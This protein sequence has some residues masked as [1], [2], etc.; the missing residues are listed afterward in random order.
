MNPSIR[1]LEAFSLVYK[2]GSVSKAADRM[3]ISQSAVSVLLRQLETTLETRLFDRTTRSLQPTAAA[4]EAIVSANR[5]LQEVGRLAHAMKSLA[6]KSLGRVTFAVTAALAAS[7]FPAILK[8]FM[9]RYPQVEIVIQDVPH[10]Q[11]GRI[12]LDDEVEFSI[13]GPP[14]SKNPELRYEALAN[15]LV[16][17]IDLN[18]GQAAGSTIKWSEVL[19]KPTI[20]IHR[21]VGIRDLIDRILLEHS[22]EFTPT[23]EV[24]FLSTALAMT[25]QG[26]GISILPGYLCPADLYPTLR[27]RHLVAPQILR[28]L[29]IVTRPDRSLSAAAEAFIAI[30]RERLLKDLPPVG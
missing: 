1:Q 23:F 19:G 3:F 7:I 2:L 29:M 6:D 11:L 24:Q 30:A 18:D 10:D 25:A 12:L 8:D 9:A 5:I 27:V 16:S 21:G 20:A 14:E 4:Q 15:Y 26:L 13:G 28:Q 22:L 17:A